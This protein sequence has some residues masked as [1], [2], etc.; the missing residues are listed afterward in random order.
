MDAGFTQR[1]RRGRGR[2]VRN[3]FPSG[4]APHQMTTQFLIIDA[5][6]T[7]WENNIYF[8]R[9][10]TGFV[11]FLAH[12]SL[13]PAEVR[14]VLDEIELTNAKIHGYGSLKFGRNM[15]ETYRRLV[16]RDVCEDDVR[17]VM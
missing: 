2:R 1:H 8:E 6:D 12:S 17:R 11:E 15:S 3:T 7:L 14:A 9:A 4:P 16:E 5:D 13:S 10:F